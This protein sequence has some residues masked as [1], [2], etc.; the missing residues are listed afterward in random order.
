VAEPT[1]ERLCPSAR[2]GPGAFLFGVV[3]PD[4]RV[5]YIGS[6][7]VVDDNFMRRATQGR[8]PEKRFRF[9]DRCVQS[10][11][12][13]WNNERCDVAA[14][15]VGHAAVSTDINLKSLPRCGIRPNCRW[16]AQEG[17]NACR[18]C[19]LVVTDVSEAGVG[20]AT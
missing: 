13:F 10:G 5:A 7:V 18:A 2:A 19:P 4:S 17:A 9:A 12:V 11:C 14:A 6:P 1:E 15:A 3:G 20:A 8:A 16:F